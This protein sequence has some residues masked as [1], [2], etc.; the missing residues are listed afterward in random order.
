MDDKKY[1]VF[2]SDTHFSEDHPEITQRFIDFLTWNKESIENLYLLGDL[3]DTWIGDDNVTPLSQKISD[4]L[5]GCTNTGTKIYFIHGNRDYLIGE[6]F[7][8]SCG[9]TLLDDKTVISLYGKN[10]LLMHGDLL[11]TDDHAYQR[12]RKIMFSPIMKKICLM[13]PLSFRKK[14]A[15]KL[16]KA[17]Q[18]SNATK[19]MQIMDVS[20]ESVIQA[21]E[22]NHTELL[23]H[24]HT[25]RQASHTIK[26]THQSAE[27]LVLGAWDGAQGNAIIASAAG[28]PRFINFHDATKN[29]AA[30]TES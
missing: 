28:K 6:K 25:H 26:L 11:C 20:E 13:L 30:L 9:M 21:L 10:T 1:T 27:R 17:S 18:K 29:L 8:Q 19:S 4:A 5:A 15:E 14:V 24:G 23:I 2:I 16:R 3:F 7:A 22:E 12:Y